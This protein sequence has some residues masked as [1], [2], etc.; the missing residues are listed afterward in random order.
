MKTCLMCN[1]AKPVEDFYLQSSARAKGTQW[2]VSYCKPCLADRNRARLSGRSQEQRDRALARRR[3]TKRPLT[4]GEKLDAKARHARWREANRDHVRENARV[5]FHAYRK[6]H[7]DLI[8]AHQVASDVTKG[9]DRSQLRVAEWRG[10]LD[11]FDHRCA[12]CGKRGK[13]SIEHVVAL[14]RG[15]TNGA[16]NIIP[17]CM[18]CNLKKHAR[19]ILC[20]VNVSYQGDAHGN[21]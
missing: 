6:A 11:M 17:A 14:S 9:C 2:R 13:L 8:R 1:V 18:P 19:G 7:P 5:N 20:M 16:S 3:E 12:Y 15:G 10:I 21:V 4:D